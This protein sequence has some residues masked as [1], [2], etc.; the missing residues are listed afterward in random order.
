MEYR[1]KT[2][3]HGHGGSRPHRRHRHDMERHRIVALAP[4]D[5]RRGQEADGRPIPTIMPIAIEELLRAYSPV[6]MA[7]VVAKD[8]EYKGCPMKA[9]DKI[10]MNFP[11]A[12]RDPEE[13]ENPDEVNLDRAHNRHVAFGSGHPPV[14]GLEP[15]ADGAAGSRSKSGSPGS[16]TSGSL[17]GEH[18]AWAGGQVRGP[19][20]LPVVF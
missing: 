7:R 4:G 14:C 15:C 13:F 17:P 18:V 10:L 2:R 6:T 11:A 5:P 3:D 20:S 1:S 12:N 8:V 16:R 9:E 19:R